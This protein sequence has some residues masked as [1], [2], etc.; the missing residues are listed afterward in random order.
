MVN[1]PQEVAADPEEILHQSVHREKALRLRS[2]FEAPHLALAL[3]DRLVGDLRAIVGVLVCAVDHRRHHGVAGRRITARL[4]GDQPSRNAWRLNNLRK[5]RMAARRLRL[6]CT[7]MSSTIVPQEFNFDDY[8]TV[9]EI[10]RFNAGYFGIR[11][12][13]AKKRVDELLD[14]FNL[15]HKKDTHVRR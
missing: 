5:K 4:V 14:Q 3:P 6:D 11:R 1:G 9:D 10:L 15:A 8:F 13:D 7:R 2:G 12:H